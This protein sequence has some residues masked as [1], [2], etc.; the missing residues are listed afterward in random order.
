MAFVATALC[1]FALGAVALPLTT[2]IAQ[3]VHLSSTP[4]QYVA[5]LDREHVGRLPE[6]FAPEPIREAPPSDAPQHDSAVASPAPPEETA[7]PAPVK[8]VSVAKPTV[9][10]AARRH[11]SLPPRRQVSS[12]NPY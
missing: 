8:P 1:S 7:A 6:T 4:A 5:Q 9:A 2:A 12:D 3:R 11:G 10:R